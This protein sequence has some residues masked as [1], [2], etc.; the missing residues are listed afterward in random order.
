MV[1]DEVEVRVVRALDMNSRSSRFESHFCPWVQLLPQAW[2]LFLK[3]INNSKAKDKGNH[4]PWRVW[5]SDQKLLVFASL[6]LLQNQFVWEV[7][8]N[9]RHSVSPQHQKP[10]SLSKILR[11]ASYFQLSS[12]CLICDETVCLVFDILHNQLVCLLSV[13]IIFNYSY[14]NSIWLSYLFQRFGYSAP[15]VH[16]HLC[17]SRKINIHTYWV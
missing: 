13:E 17:I 15:L 10:R 9:T 5:I 11:Y 4:A 1:I 6:I 14:L 16:I 7:I 2:K 12:R 3:L 8:S